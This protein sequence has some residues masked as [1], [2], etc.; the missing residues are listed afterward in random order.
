MTGRAW[1]G[2]AFGRVKGRIVD[3]NRCEL[4]KVGE[5]RYWLFPSILFALTGTAVA[6]PTQITVRVIARNAQFVGDMV[7]G[8]QITITDALSGEMLAQGITTGDSGDPKRTMTTA[9][10]RGTPMAVSTDAKFHATLDLDEPRQLRVSAFGPLQRRVSANKVSATQWV[11][12]GKHLSGGDGWVLEL[13]GFMVQGK[14]AASTVDLK[15]ARA[16]LTVEAEVMLMCGCHVK[17][18]FY[19]DADRYEVGMLVQRGDQPVGEF[20]LQYA[21]A[22]SEFAGGLAVDLPGLYHITVY[23]YDP[24]SGNTGV[25]ALTLTVVESE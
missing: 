11:V 15:A 2:T 5:M 13:P 18:G 21:N 8:A 22:A 10:D 7:A 25:D 6:E 12:P 3:G 23:A 20:P 17:P 1:R 9:R 16:G 19:W 14:L 4:H 24:E